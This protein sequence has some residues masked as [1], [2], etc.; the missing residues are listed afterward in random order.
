MSQN[1]N[2]AKLNKAQ[3]D[4]EYRNIQNGILYPIYWDEGVMFYPRY[5]RGFKN[6]GKTIERYQM[7]AYRSWK[8]N[9]K[10]QYKVKRK[11]D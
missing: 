6:S 7:R 9:R 11:R 8:H 4:R 1:R 2:R 3:V 5:R 10:E